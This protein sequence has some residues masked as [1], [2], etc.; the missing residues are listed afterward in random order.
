MDKVIELLGK[1]FEGW[2]LLVVLG[3]FLIGLIAFNVFLDPLKEWAAD[4]TRQWRMDRTERKAT[5]RVANPP[6]P[7]D[8]APLRLLGLVPP[9][10]RDYTSDIIGNL[11]WEWE[12]VDGANRPDIDFIN[13]LTCRCPKCDKRIVPLMGWTTK[14]E[15]QP[16]RPFTAGVQHI[17]KNDKPYL[18]YGCDDRCGEVIQISI[19]LVRFET[20]VKTTIEQRARARKAKD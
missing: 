9:G 4:A 16:Q 15:R 17:L 20:A 1:T 12:W 10:F 11:K 18:S 19:S 13:R 7:G 8:S 14:L 3:I 6:P 2:H 5:E